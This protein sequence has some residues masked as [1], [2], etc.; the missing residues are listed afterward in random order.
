MS[1]KTS[2]FSTIFLAIMFFSILVIMVVVGN[3]FGSIITDFGKKAVV[4]NEIDM[5][6][7]KLANDLTTIIITLPHGGKIKY[8]PAIPSSVAGVS[9]NISLNLNSDILQI[10]SYY[11]TVNF[12]LGG[13]HYEINGSISIYEINISRVT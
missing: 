7:N 2:G 8:V 4:K 9:Y 12:T 1:Q 10:K 11:H 13:I 5:I 3:T 6:G